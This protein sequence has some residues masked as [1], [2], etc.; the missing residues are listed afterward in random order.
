MVDPQD[1]EQ[2]EN[3]VINAPDNLAAV[4]VKVVPGTVE[5]KTTLVIPQALE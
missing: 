3:P 2:L 1:E 4:Q 5:F